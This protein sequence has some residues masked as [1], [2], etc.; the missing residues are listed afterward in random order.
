LAVRAAASRTTIIQSLLAVALVASVAVIAAEPQ[1]VL[2]RETTTQT[3]TVATTSILT[4]TTTEVYRTTI[5]Q[6]AQSALTTIITRAASSSAS[7]MCTVSAPTGPFY[8][9][10]LSDSGGVPIAGAK[11]AA[12]NRPVLCNGS[13]LGDNVTIIFTTG[14]A[15]WYSLRGDGLDSSW[16]VKV[17]YSARNYTLSTYLQPVSATCATIF[18]PS[19]RTNVTF[20]EFQSTCP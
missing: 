1:L 9:R 14:S 19:G 8:F 7:V 10:A 4:V 17:D 18:L 2:K 20:Y 12:S 6:S 11:V 15:P 16:S 5:T 13:P 3:E